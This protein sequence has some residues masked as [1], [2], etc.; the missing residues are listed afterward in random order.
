MYD[1]SSPDLITWQ[2]WATAEVGRLI[3]TAENTAAN[4][5]D[6][7]TLDFQPRE[8]VDQGDRTQLHTILVCVLPLSCLQCCHESSYELYVQEKIYTDHGPLILQLGGRD[9]NKNIWIKL[10]KPIPPSPEQDNSKTNTTEHVIDDKEALV[11][12]LW[13]SPRGVSLLPKV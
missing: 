2:S 4:T 3:Q 1:L 13:I 11:C 7:A 10:T 8:Q 6:Q 12:V 5:P 9:D